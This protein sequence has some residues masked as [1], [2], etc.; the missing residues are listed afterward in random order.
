MPPGG[1]GGEGVRYARQYGGHEQDVKPLLLGDFCT[2]LAIGHRHSPGGGSG[3]GV[4]YVG[5]HGGR[6]QDEAASFF[7]GISHQRRPQCA[8]PRHEHVVAT[9]CNSEQGGAWMMR[10]VP[11]HTAPAPAPAGRAV[12]CHDHRPAADMQGSTEKEDVGIAPCNF[13]WRRE[14]RTSAAPSALSPAMNTLSRRP[15]A[16]GADARTDVPWLSM[17]C[18]TRERPECAVPRHIYV[19]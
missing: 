7:E 11:G 1:G 8:V 17:Y 19:V 15:A 2:S 10:F 6:Q 12:R 3:E 13:V 9:T 5:Q 4:G 14:S 16:C 18:L